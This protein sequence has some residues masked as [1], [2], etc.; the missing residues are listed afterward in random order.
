M[1]T[2]T[3]TN[4]TTQDV[5]E[6]L[7]FLSEYDEERH[8]KLERLGSALDSVRSKYGQNAVSFG[9]LLSPK[10]SALNQTEQ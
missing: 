8:E 4:L 3:G 7:S 5:G 9:S 1:L 6:Q 10:D 2:V